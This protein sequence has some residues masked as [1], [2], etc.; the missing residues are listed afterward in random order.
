MKETRTVKVQNGKKEV[1]TMEVEVDFQAV[2]VRI[3][4]RA[5]ENGKNVSTALGGAIKVTLKS[6]EAK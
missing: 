5:I 1:F 3:G 6:K 4:Q 2:A